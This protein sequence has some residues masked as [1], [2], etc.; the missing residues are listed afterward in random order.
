VALL[1]LVGCA[2]PYRADRT[3]KTVRVYQGRQDGMVMKVTLKDTARGGGWFLFSDPKADAIGAKH[4]NQPGLGGYNVFKMGEFSMTVDTNTAA[5]FN[6][7]GGAVG[8]VIGK[9]AGA[10][11]GKP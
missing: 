6:S 3:I 9:A 4:V 1:S 10:V 5:I 7:V 11:V 8:E 2:V